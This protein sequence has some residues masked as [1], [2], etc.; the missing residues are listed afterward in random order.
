MSYLAVNHVGS[1]HCLHH[2]WANNIAFYYVQPLEKYKII[3]Q[4]SDPINIYYTSIAPSQYESAS[5][6]PYYGL[7]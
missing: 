6:T 1:L 5:R 2:C 4:M 7:P 3:V